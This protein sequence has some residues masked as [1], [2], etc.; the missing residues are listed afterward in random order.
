MSETE[1]TQQQWLAANMPNNPSTIQD[2]RHPVEG[3]SWNECRTYIS[4]LNVQ[5]GGFRV[6]TE[7]EWEYACRGNTT[8]A[9][10]FGESLSPDDA[11]CNK[12]PFDRNDAT[13]GGT[14]PAG[15]MPANAFG[16]REM[17]G[18]VREWCEDLLQ[19]YPKQGSQ[20]AAR[21]RSGADR[22]VRGGSWR[23]SV[24]DCRS[25]SRNSC[26]SNMSCKGIGLRLVRD[27]K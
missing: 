20:A 27:L 22:V 10:G 14:V 25:A 6:P 15:S 3:V 18:N 1:V 12:H 2:D 19:T 5:S 17:H 23:S 9:F 24:F 8:T 7:A 21:Y 13:A 16:L 11:C 26:S 4:K